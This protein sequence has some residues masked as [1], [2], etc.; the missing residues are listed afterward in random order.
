M[1]TLKLNSGAEMPVLGLGTWQS[2]PGKVGEA[3]T[4][5]LKE[6]NY[7]HID[8]AWIY[9]NEKEVGAAF[10]D[11]FGG[12]RKREE[13]FVTSKLWNSFH[14]KKNV[15]KACKETLSNL[16]LEYLDMYLM[17]WGLPSPYGESEPMGA[18]GVLVLDDVPIRETWEAMQELQKE[19]LV[20]AIGVSNFTV[21]MLTDLLTYADIEPATNQIELH[22]YLQ[23]QRLLDF[24]DSKGIVVTAYSPL[25]RPGA[26]PPREYME[27]TPQRIVD[28]P[29]L[30]KIAQAHGKTTAQVILRWGIERGT[31]VIPKSTTPSRIAENIDIFD[32][33]LSKEEMNTIVSLERN[34]RF[35]D[36]MDWWKIPYF[37]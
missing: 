31:I 2:D 29:S 20:N 35:V 16:G 6:A 9:G 32:L 8:C 22:P 23:Q 28:E 36:P 12:A 13:I 18:D 25:G 27:V 3:V 24:C 10:K 34:M 21:P 30:K 7:A 19:G 26:Q 17:H 1:K 14:A 11:V 15:A 5:A 37:N 4:Y 33:E